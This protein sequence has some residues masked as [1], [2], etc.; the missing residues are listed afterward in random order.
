[1]IYVI[2]VE[3][4]SKGKDS[5][6]FPSWSLSEIKKADIEQVITSVSFTLVNFYSREKNYANDGF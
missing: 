6:V 4:I 1:M 2:G 3:H 5:I